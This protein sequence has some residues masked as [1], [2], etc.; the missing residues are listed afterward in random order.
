MGKKTRYGL[1]MLVGFLDENLLYFN[2]L[3]FSYTSPIF[4]LTFHVHP[5][6]DLVREVPLESFPYFS[7]KI[8]VVGTH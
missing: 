1:Y 4:R 2:L 3:M 6:I 7:T 8:Y 5:M